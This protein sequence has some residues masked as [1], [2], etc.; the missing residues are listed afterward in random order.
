MN[1][2]V[3]IVI[4]AAGKGTR[5][6]ST[7]PKPF[8]NLKGKPILEH[9]HDS[10]KETG[11]ETLTVISEE[12]VD[13]FKSKF[14]DLPYYILKEALGT[15]HAVLAVQKECENAESIV[16]LYGD[17]PFVT[18]PTIKKLIDKS[19]ET[20]AEITLASTVVPN[21]ENEYKVFSHFG[22]ILRNAGNIIAIREY[23]DATEGERNV[24]E[25]SPGYYVFRA[26]WLWANLPKI[27]NE[28]AKGEYY[29][30]DL[31]ALALKDNKKIEGIQIPVREAMGVN[32]QEELEILEKLT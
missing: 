15:A 1:N 9:L 6:Q 31:L 20:G 29:L 10:I 32:S 27:S 7:I 11:Y 13:I 16:V 5:M 17:H 4:L 24:M 3:K 12:A 19:M 2:K 14:P 21:F 22:R 25:V 26:S 30:T 18:A 23:K 8:I 28:N